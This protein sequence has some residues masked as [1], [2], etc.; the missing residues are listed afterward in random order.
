MKKWLITTKTCVDPAQLNSK[1]S[2]L[3]C[4]QT[5]P[6][7]PLDD[8]EQVIEVEGPNDLPAKAESEV[9]ILKIN[10]SSDMELY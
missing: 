9:E 3:G 4:Q 10:P 6:P 1:L 5:S 7:I 8:N 2:A